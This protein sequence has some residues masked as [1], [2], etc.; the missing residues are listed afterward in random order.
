MVVS[1][2]PIAN[3]DVLVVVKARTEVKIVIFH[4]NKKSIG[5]L[6]TQID[7]LS[8]F[9]NNLN[10]TVVTEEMRVVSQLSKFTDRF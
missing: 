7:Q 8:N 1:R 10:S 4:M 3:D 2:C 6:M 9:C 5:I